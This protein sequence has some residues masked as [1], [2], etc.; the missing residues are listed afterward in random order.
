MTFHWELKP[1][2][3]SPVTRKLNP[4]ELFFFFSLCSAQLKQKRSQYKER[5]RSMNSTGSGKSST[6]SSVSDV[7]EQSVEQPEVLLALRLDCLTNPQT[8]SP[9]N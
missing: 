8:N 9:A 1:T 3:F 6:V 2:I 4:G 7:L 5:G